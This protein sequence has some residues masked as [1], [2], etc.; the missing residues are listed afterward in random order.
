MRT[1][2]R[3][4][5]ASCRGALW[6]VGLFSLVVNLLMLTGPMFMLQV[7]DRVMSSR[8]TPTLVALFVLVVVLFAFMGVLEAVRHRVLV[9]VGHRFDEEVGRAA[10]DA[11]VGAALKLGPTGEA[12]R[13]LRDLDQL[14]QAS[15]GTGIIAFFDLP[16]LPVYMGV[17]FLFHWMLGVLGIA[18]ALVLIGLTI[19]TEAAS[20]NGSKTVSE[21]GQKRAALA[22]AGRRNVEVLTGMGMLG[23]FA[24]LWGRTNDAYLAAS[25]A[26]TDTV[27]RYSVISRVF[28]LTLQSGALAVGGWLAIH[29]QISA[30]A[31]VAGSIIMSRGL[32]PIEQIV[33]N[34]RNLVQAKEAYQRLNGALKA[35]ATP[36]RMSLP[37]PVSALTAEGV[38]VVPP[39]A[40]RPVLKGIGLRLDAGKA[41]GVIGPMGCGKTSL[42]R[43]LVGVWPVA[44]GKVALD[45]APIDQWA[46]D[47]LGRHIGYLPQDVEL[48][49]GT[50]EEN[51]GRFDPD[52]TPELVVAAAQA[53]G[54]HELILT[55]PDGYNTRLGE[56]GQVLSGGQR[57]QVGLARALYGE[58]FLVVLDEPNSNLDGAGDSALGR[59]VDVVKARGGVAV[60]ITHRMST[61]QSVDDL[62]VLSKGGVVAYGPKA[63]VL[64]ELR[65]R[66][67]DAAAEPVSAGEERK[68]IGGAHG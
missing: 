14:R 35:I 31:I 26:L 58:P 11:Q 34:W 10:F 30:G 52:R 37:A 22:E 48:F 49:D 53:A 33:G 5:V 15:A 7:Y 64:A 54:V 36:D 57:Q 13:P 40:T 24:G 16:W 46:P 39:G 3:R 21:L 56:S 18:G 67:V 20:R 50:V 44:A 32:Q 38:A 60:I 28:R 8:S 63:T 66:P 45:G 19:A 43:A 51:I 68:Q 59:A 17:L 27:N 25:G 4:V 6:A 1:P 61:I 23:R 29:E 41:L 9:R 12:I 55:L 42:A 65:R 2:I 62:L 47:E